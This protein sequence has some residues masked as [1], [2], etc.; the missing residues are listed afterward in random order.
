M[1]SLYTQT[2]VPQ[3]LPQERAHDDLRPVVW[4]D[5]NAALSISEHVMATLSS[6]PVKPCRLRYLAQIPVGD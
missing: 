2:H 3:Y 1:I 5:Y 6:G 4:Y